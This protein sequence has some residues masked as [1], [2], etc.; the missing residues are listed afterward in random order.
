M[1]MNV[2]GTNDTK[3]KNKRRRKV[4]KSKALLGILAFFLVGCTDSFQTEEPLV[5]YPIR[6][7]AIQLIYDTTYRYPD[8]YYFDMHDEITQSYTLYQVKDFSNSYELCTDDELEAIRLEQEDN[9]RR[10]VNGQLITYTQNE[11]Y[12]EFVRELDVSGSIGN[13]GLTEPGFA[14]IYK[15]SYVNRVG[16]DRNDFNGYGGIMNADLS[17]QVVREFIQYTNFFTFWWPQTAKTLQFSS[18]ENNDEFIH[19]LL[20]G[21]RTNQGTDRC[22]LIQL[23]DWRWTVN[24]SNGEMERISY[25]VDQFEADL[26]NGVPVICE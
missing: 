5:S 20:L 3:L 1:D 9:D 11:R 26:V 25:L 23:L 17:E 8:G 16:V 6:Q 7:E 15:C 2:G 19:T 4:K 14:R 12:F 18:E 22:D 13:T 10:V 21:L 24:K